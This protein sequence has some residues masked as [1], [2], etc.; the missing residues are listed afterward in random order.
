M[1]AG[2][3]SNDTVSSSAISCII[4]RGA[5]SVVRVSVVRVLSWMIRSR[6]ER[7]G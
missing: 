2:L 4:G 1:S 3:V 5:V 6:A 7:C